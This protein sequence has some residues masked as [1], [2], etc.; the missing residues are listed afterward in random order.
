VSGQQSDLGRKRE[1]AA[2]GI[3]VCLIESG[4]IR[5]ADRAGEKRISDETQRLLGILNLIADSTRSMSGGRQAPDGLAS[6][7]DG[8]TLDG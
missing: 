2:D 1:E 3:K 5:S 7:R 4:G 6:D 8:Q